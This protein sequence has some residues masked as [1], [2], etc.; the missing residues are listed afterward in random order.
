[1]V[2]C[3]VSCVVSI[4]VAEP[5]EDIKRGFTILLTLRPRLIFLNQQMIAV[6][7]PFPSGHKKFRMT[8]C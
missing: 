8:G 2:K 3:V 6:L 4:N 5:T 1:M 7:M